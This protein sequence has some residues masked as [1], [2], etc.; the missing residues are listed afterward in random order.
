M[1]GKVDQRV[2]IGNEAIK[3]IKK[4]VYRFFKEIDRFIIEHC[5]SLRSITFKALSKKHRNNNTNPLK[6]DLQ[7]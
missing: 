5:F 7:T 2:T 3:K 1:H 6:V 4:V